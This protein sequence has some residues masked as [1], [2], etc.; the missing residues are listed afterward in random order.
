MQCALSIYLR[1]DSRLRESETGAF[2]IEGQRRCNSGG[3][4]GGYGD[5]NDEVDDDDDEDCD[6][7]TMVQNN[8][9]Y[10]LRYR[11]TRSSIPSHRLLIRLLAHS[12][13]RSH[14]HSPACGT[15]ND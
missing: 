1:C 12:F 7:R 14:T 15:A 10:R 6:R 8:K 3:D 2:A 9:K 13:A 5:G 4:G 11:A